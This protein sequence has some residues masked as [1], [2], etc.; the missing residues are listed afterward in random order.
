MRLYDKSVNWEIEF[1]QFSARGHVP[2][3]P[4]VIRPHHAVR[5]RELKGRVSPELFAEIHSNLRNTIAL[6][7]KIL[8]SRPL[9]LLGYALA[10]KWEHECMYVPIFPE[11]VNTLRTDLSQGML[12][13][14][15][16]RTFCLLVCY[17]NIK[18]KVH[19]TVILPVVYGCETWSL[20][21]RE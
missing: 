12:V 7:F 4:S 20:I 13:I 2:I 8:C 14:I 10:A 5:W 15:R 18:I 1:S 11:F 9:R 17:P 6:K 21:L 19:G 16:C 3:S